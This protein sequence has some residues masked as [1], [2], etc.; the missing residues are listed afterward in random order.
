LG[1]APHRTKQGRGSY[2][3]MHR[4]FLG[5]VFVSVTGLAFGLMVALDRL[6]G[7]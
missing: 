3:N 7:G 4:I 2:Q 5:I 6:I 1:K